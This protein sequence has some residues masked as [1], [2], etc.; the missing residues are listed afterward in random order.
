MIDTTV[1]QTFS[2][3]KEQLCGFALRPDGGTLRSV[4]QHSQRIDPKVT[5]TD[6]LDS[7]Q[8]MLKR[9]WLVEAGW[10]GRDHLYSVYKG[11]WASTEP[12]EKK[13]L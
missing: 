8:Y 13:P 2:E 7:A 4:L 1:L 5:M 10:F 6:V 11:N 3:F 9:G 12:R